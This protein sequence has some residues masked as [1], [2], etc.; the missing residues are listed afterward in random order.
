MNNYSYKI[1]Y[2]YESLSL[3]NVLVEPAPYFKPHMDKSAVDY[4]I[5]PGPR[6]EKFVELLQRIED[7]ARVEFAQDI[8]DIKS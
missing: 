5:I 2:V 8:D 6:E 7:D 3:L 4:D 1:H